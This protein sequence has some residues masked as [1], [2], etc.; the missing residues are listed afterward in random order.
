LDGQNALH[1]VRYRLGNA[2]HRTITDYQRMEHQQQLIAAV[3]DELL[4]PRTITRIPELINT[5][6][7]HIST[8]LSLFELLWFAEQFVLGEI[9]L[10]TYNYP[11]LSTRI[12]VSEE[13]SL[14]YE[15]PQATEALELINRTINPFTRELTLDN[16][17]LLQ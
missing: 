9:T 3:K 11:T 7:D 8:D 17:Q 10:N 1:F 14:W 5:Y 16:L 15:V 2:G 4:S 6:R 12:Q 13:T